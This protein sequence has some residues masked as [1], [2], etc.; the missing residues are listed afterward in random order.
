MKLL[1]L[2]GRKVQEIFETL[3][4][5]PSVKEV[6]R[7][8]LATG[9][10]PHLSEYELAIAKLNEF[11]EPKKN[12]TYE[13][14]VFRL[15]KQ[16]K[17]EKISI[18]TMRLRTQADK[19]DFGEAMEDNVKDQIIEKCSSSR[20]RRELLKLGDAKLDKVLKTA[21]IFEAIEEQS[22]TFDPSDSKPFGEEIV[23]K[24]ESKAPFKGFASQKDK[25]IECSRCGFT[26]H[27]SYEDKCPA[28][29]KTCNKCGGR[30]HF[31]RK[32]KSKSRSQNQYNS[33][34]NNKESR[35]VKSEVK[36]DENESQNKRPKLENDEIVKL[37][38]TYQSNVK[39]DYIFCIDCR[40]DS[41]HGAGNV[42]SLKIGNVQLL[43]VLDSGSK[44]NII[45]LKTWEF[46]KAG[47]VEILSQ[48]TKVDH[49]FK[50]YGEH[51][52]TTIGS[53]TAKIETRYSSQIANF[54]VVKDYG[55]ALIGYQTGIPLGV[56]KIGEQV[57]QIDQVKPLNKIKGV[58]I[59]I[60]INE[61]VKPVAQPYRRVPVALEEAV[62]KKIDE[63]LSQ[64][65]IEKVF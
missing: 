44:Y 65:I 20:L 64:G 21:K 40:S 3:P 63:L 22:K 6:A 62:D 55:K 27:R 11:F 50:S 37:V 61:N 33:S 57:N 48:S 53:F 38:E 43:V 19:C 39:D 36:S 60:P 2:A 30:N 32:C 25:Q 35:A 45:D 10:T 31:S 9:F 52:L 58:I 47:K 28:R 29:G 49:E 13:R 14:H 54:I 41:D 51:R 56:I 1:H 16:E 26:G 24:I 23:N 12:S 7:G 5:P 17:N 34:F 46:L 8:P 15:I 59:D 18:F 42:I 4:I